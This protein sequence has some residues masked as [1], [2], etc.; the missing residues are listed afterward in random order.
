M[1]SINA[2]TIFTVQE[3]FEMIGIAQRFIRGDASRGKNV[4]SAEDILNALEDVVN[5]RMSAI[6]ATMAKQYLD[7]DVDDL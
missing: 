6:A 1:T 3:A 2:R 7:I 5:D 4:F